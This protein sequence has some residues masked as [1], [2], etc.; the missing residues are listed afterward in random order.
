[1]VPSPIGHAVISA[2]GFNKALSQSE[3][4]QKYLDGVSKHPPETLLYI[5]QDYVKYDGTPNL[6]KISVPTLIIGGEN[7]LITPIEHLE[8]LHKHIQ[9]SEF[10]RIPYASH[11]THLDMPEFVNLK[12]DQWLRKV[13]GA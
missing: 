1:V 6:K 2:L 10:I 13:F 5:L 11:C 3:D 9:G 7:D 12:L 4:I 8:Y